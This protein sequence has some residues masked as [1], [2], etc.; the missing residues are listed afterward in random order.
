PELVGVRLPRGSVLLFVEVPDRV[1]VGL[2][3]LPPVIGD[4]VDLAALLVADPHEAGL[5]EQLERRIDDAGARTIGALAP[6]LDHLHDLVAVARRV[7]EGV[8]QQ[9]LHA[10]ALGPRAGLAEP[11]DEEAEVAAGPPAAAPAGPP[12]PASHPER[13]RVVALVVHEPLL[14]R[15]RERR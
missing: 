1:A 14:R 8:E 3:L 5:R 4:L 11:A 15:C 2:E 12:A 7:G 10:S 9:V 6:L 13:E